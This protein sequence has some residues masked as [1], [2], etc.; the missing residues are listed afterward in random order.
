MNNDCSL[1]YK[2]CIFFYCVFWSIIHH[3]ICSYS[4]PLNGHKIWLH[5]EECKLRITENRLLRRMH[6]PKRKLREAKGNCAMM[7]LM[8]HTGFEGTPNHS[9]GKQI[10]NRLG[11]NT[12][13]FTGFRIETCGR[14]LLGW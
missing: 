9:S 6:G 12:L 14:F 8:I 1:A 2:I 11:G 3:F 7:G 10:L 13:L 5:R 4:S